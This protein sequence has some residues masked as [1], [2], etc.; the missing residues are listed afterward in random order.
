ML[1]DKKYDMATEN[2]ET[3]SKKNTNKQIL[4]TSR[5]R[6]IVQSNATLHES[7]KFDYCS[8]TPLVSYTAPALVASFADARDLST[9]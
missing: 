9:A 3:S 7:T 8:Y 6:F 4:K 2:G 1:L 5:M